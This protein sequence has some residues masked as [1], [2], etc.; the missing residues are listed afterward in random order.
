M[1]WLKR[2]Y[3]LVTGPN[4]IAN[5]YSQFIERCWIPLLVRFFVDS[6]FF[7]ALFT[8]DFSTQALSYFGWTRFAWVISLVIGYA[9]FA[10]AFGFM[11]DVIVDFAIGKIPFIKDV[12]PQMPAP[13]P[14][15]K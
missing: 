13:L 14:S 11:I 7:W 12:L 8:P 4:S 9:A 3:Y 15:P 10:A 6:L 5:S 1:Y 2:A